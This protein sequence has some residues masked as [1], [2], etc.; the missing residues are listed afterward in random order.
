M[1]PSSTSHTNTPVERAF[2]R[3]KGR[4]A[5]QPFTQSNV[6]AAMRLAQS[7]GALKNA[8]QNNRSLGMEELGEESGI[9]LQGVATS[10]QEATPEAVE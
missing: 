3:L 4:L 10:H 1:S 9:V 6:I 8:A 2:A 5:N 7:S